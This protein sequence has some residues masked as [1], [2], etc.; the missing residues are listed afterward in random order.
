MTIDL[1]KIQYMIYEIRGQRVMLDS[2]LAKLY[3]V[4]TKAL[5][6][7][8]KRNM[9]R[10]PSDFMFKCDSNE[11]ANLRSQ[12]VT[13]NH[14]NSWNFKAR[15]NPLLFTENGIAMLSGILK[16]ERAI[17]VNI[18]IMRIFTRLRSFYLLETELRDEMKTLKSDT[19]KVFKI[20]FERLDSIEKNTPLIS[21]NRKKIGL[22]KN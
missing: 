9:K 6:Q 21:P 7:A 20:V 3:G 17:E 14:V 12:F 8:V 10:F 16:S 18:S 1:S 5:N 4:E 13:A 11:L 2:D 19:N 22:K 15:S